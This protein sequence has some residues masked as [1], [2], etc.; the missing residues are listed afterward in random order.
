[1]IRP[2]NGNA[3]GN[4]KSRENATAEHVVE[5][6]SQPID[7]DSF[8]RDFGVVKQNSVASPPPQNGVNRDFVGPTP[9]AGGGRRGF[10]RG[11]PFSSARGRGK[12][13][14]P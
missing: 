6:P 11:G 13:W 10:P 7:P 3:T 12:L 1:M 4:I 8:R 14:V 2:T 5:L 9:R